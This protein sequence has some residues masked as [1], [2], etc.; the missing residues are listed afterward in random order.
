[1]Q[2]AERWRRAACLR[3]PNQ[4]FICNSPHSRFG[5]FSAAFTLTQ[6]HPIH[7]TQQNILKLN[8]IIDTQ[9]LKRSNYAF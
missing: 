8:E 7:V 9:Q 4:Q 6:P 3:A 2:L 1:M 5:D